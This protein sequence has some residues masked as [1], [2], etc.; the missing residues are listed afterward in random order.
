[1]LLITEGV[2]KQCFILLACDQRFALLSEANERQA[3]GSDTEAG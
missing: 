3:S 1:M 2:L